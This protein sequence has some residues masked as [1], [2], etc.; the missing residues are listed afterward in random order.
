MT[1]NIYARDLL[2]PQDYYAGFTSDRGSFKDRFKDIDEEAHFVNSMRQ[3]GDPHTHN[4]VLDFGN[5]DAFCATDLE[6][7]EMKLLLKKPVCELTLSP[8]L[9]KSLIHS[10]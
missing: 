10:V 1:E 2:S 6:T 4:F 5:E 8:H 3:L 7:D 9:F